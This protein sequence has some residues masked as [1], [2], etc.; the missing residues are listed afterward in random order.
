MAGQVNPRFRRTHQSAVSRN[1]SSDLRENRPF[2]TTTGN[3]GIP[4]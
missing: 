4:R 3:L 1:F 2:G